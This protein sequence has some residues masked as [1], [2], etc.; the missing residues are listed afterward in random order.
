MEKEPEMLTGQ[1]C[2]I[3][4]EDT[5]TLMESERDIPYFGLVYLFSM[6][7]SNCKYFKADVEA[8]EKGEPKKYTV[9]VSGDDDAGI[10]IVKSS[11]ATVKIPHVTTI[12]PGA[13]SNG[14]VTNVEGILNR[15]KKQIETAMENEEDAD[16]K[17]KGRKLIKKI[18]RTLFGQEK[19]KIIL[20]DPEGNSAII[21]NKAIVKKL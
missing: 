14:Y 18:N 11:T 9:E 20:E 1:K 8:A 19:L 16:A 10:R 7:C 5:L 13:A 12:T 2:P 17:K 3:C 15:V 21:S 6:N 4:Q